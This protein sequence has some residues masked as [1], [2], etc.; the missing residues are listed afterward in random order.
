MSAYLKRF[1]LACID[2]GFNLPMA[3]VL[4]RLRRTT[5][6][7]AWKRVLDET[8]VWEQQ[9]AERQREAKA[10]KRGAA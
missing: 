2:D 6:D 8:V 9:R 3:N 5:S 7:R 10:K 1:K 4:R